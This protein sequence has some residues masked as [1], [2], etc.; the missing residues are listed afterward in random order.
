MS[1]W[2]FRTDG[3][4]TKATHPNGTRIRLDDADGSVS[5]GFHTFDELYRHRM[6][7]TASWFR[8]LYWLD[9]EESEDHQYR[10][11]KSWRHSD[12]ELCFGGGWFI[13]VATL[14]TGQ[15]SYHYPE[16]D[17][18][19]FD[20]PELDLPDEYDG[21]TPEDV[22]TRLEAYARGDV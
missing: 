10:V 11:H 2:E 16:A 22:L 5:D 15:I 3:N 14:P 21:H 6:L 1:G 9:V 18:S 17:W 19:L 7:L 4:G 13:V 12:G 8:D 20:I